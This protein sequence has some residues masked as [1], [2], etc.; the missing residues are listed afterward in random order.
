[1]GRGNEGGVEEGNGRKGK[2]MER[3]YNMAFWRSSWQYL[4]DRFRPVSQ[5]P[6]KCSLVV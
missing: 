4:K 2:G 3:I 5:A 1:M 6:D